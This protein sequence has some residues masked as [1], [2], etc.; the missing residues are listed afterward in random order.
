M[1]EVDNWVQCAACQKWRRLVSAD[2]E[3]LEKLGAMEWVCASNP[4]ASRADCSAPED[5]WEAA[6]TEFQ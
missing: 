1:A 3:A 5:D 6:T 4:D 2:A